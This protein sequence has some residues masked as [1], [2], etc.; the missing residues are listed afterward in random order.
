MQ[1]PRAATLARNVRVGKKQTLANNGTAIMPEKRLGVVRQILRLFQYLNLAVAKGHFYSTVVHY[2]TA[3]SFTTRL[4]KK[5]EVRAMF[6]VG[7]NERRHVEH[8][9][10]VEDVL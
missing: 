10:G 5:V 4:A 2:L 7:S 6:W 3:L 1:R 8:L 9:G